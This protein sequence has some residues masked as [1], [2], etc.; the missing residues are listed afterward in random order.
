MYFPKI[1]NQNSK[2]WLK[3]V[4]LKKVSQL[5]NPPISNQ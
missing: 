3:K 1:L 4:Y 5:K 2:V